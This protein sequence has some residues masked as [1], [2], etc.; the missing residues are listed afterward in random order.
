MQHYLLINNS[1]QI[2]MFGAIILP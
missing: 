1:N 2:N